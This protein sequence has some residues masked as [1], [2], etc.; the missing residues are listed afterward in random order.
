MLEEDV[1]L[2]NPPQTI[3]KVISFS[4]NGITYSTFILPKE[5]FVS[6]VNTLFGINFE[7]L[8]VNSLK[9]L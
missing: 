7:E 2:K 8:N 1:K 5:I 9:V 4:K 3:L 6:W